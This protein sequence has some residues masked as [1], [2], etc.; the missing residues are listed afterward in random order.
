MPDPSTLADLP[1]PSLLVER[2]V[3]DANVAAMAA[4][5]PGERLRPH[6]KAFKSTALAKELAAAGHTNF[7]AATVREMEGMAKAGMGADLLLANQSLDLASADALRRGG[8][9][10]SPS[11]STARRRSRP[12]WRRPF[13]RS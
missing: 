7:C 4:A 2:S 9:P 1:T 6:V 11:P 5:R 3:F 8:T 12:P 13:P 10:V